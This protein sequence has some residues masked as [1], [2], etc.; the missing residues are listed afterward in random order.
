MLSLGRKKINKVG[1]SSC[2]ILPKMILESMNEKE[3]D[4]FLN[5]KGEIVIIPVKNTKG[6]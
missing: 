6:D 1:N 5:E 4:L 3:F 2:I